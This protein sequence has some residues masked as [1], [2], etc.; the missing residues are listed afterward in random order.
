MVGEGVTSTLTGSVAALKSEGAVES[1]RR[2]TEG[3]DV[4][5]LNLFINPTFD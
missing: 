1:E 4:V 5:E 2:L 3:V